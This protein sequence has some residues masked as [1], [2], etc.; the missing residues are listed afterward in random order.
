[1]HNYG[2]GMSGNGSLKFELPKLCTGGLN[3]TVLDTWLFYMNLYF[4]MEDRIPVTKCA[5]QV[6]INFTGQAA[7]WFCV[8][9]VGMGSYHNDLGVTCRCN[10]AGV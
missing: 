4:Q 1:M 8:Y 3:A 10:E 9:C 5:T 7:D 6:V 2:T